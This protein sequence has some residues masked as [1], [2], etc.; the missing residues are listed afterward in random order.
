MDV[1]E[2]IRT[3]KT[4]AKTTDSPH[5][6]WRCGDAYAVSAGDDKPDLDAHDGPVRPVAGYDP[7]G[8]EHLG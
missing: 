2:A 7:D 4:L 6:V 5:T 1:R 3:A 8:T